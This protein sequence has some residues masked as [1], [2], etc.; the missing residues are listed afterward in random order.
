MPT[1]SDNE[2]ACLRFIA[3]AVL[4]PYF[5][6]TSGFIF[7]VSGQE[8]TDRVDAPY[9]IALS[10]HRLDIAGVF[11]RQDGAAAEWLA[12]RFSGEHP[13]YADL[14]GVLLL[15]DQVELQGQI[16]PF[17]LD[18]DKWHEYG[19]IYLRTRNVEKHEAVFYGQ[20]AGLRKT[21]SFSQMGL[22]EVINGNNRIYNNGGA[23]V[24]AQR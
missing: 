7:E 15:I 16:S 23:Q 4:V 2:R 10:S 21:I 13:V 1:E 12:D 14:H 22:P 9:S 3:L 18:K 8:V 17:P 5:L 20:S 19:Y 6:V 24:L 11:N